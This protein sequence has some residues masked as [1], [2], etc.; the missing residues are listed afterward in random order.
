[1]SR[2]EAS[3]VEPPA[4]LGRLRGLQRLLFGRRRQA[5]RAQAQAS[6]QFKKRGAAQLASGTRQLEIH[7]GLQQAFDA[8]PGTRKTLHHLAHLEGALARTGDEALAV[9]PVGVLV[10]A[11]RQLEI[12]LQV[13]APSHR[14]SLL[15]TRMEQVIS[16]RKGAVP[17]G[18]NNAESLAGSVGVSEA[19]LAEYDA[20]VADSDL[21]DLGAR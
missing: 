21:A 6:R 20:A 8:R 7:R 12:L 4:P 14:L 15:A 9:L 18:R 17:A 19:S 5:A 3:R 13:S 1:M 10:K 11:R 2:F 16:R